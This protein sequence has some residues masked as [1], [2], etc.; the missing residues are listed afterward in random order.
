MLVHPG[1]V[2]VNESPAN[3]GLEYETVTLTSEDGYD[4]AAWYIPSQNGAA[5]ILQHGY[6]NNRTAMLPKAEIL[7]RHSY[8][9][10]MVDLRA[11]GLSEGD[12]VSFG[13][14]EVRDVDAA[15]QYL[16]SRPDVDPD[17]IGALGDS[18]GGAVVLLY[19]AQNPQIKAVVSEGAYASLQDV[20]ATGVETMTGLPAFPF[21]SMIQWFAEWEGGFDADEVAPIEQIGSIS[22]RPVFLM[23][24]GA[25]RLIPPDNGQR[26]YEAAGKPRELWFEPDLGHGRGSFKAER[27]EEYEA[28][29]VGFFDQYL[30]RE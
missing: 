6:P 17:R 1:R 9:V 18:M 26:L 14:F 2:P 12:T 21:A 28:R 3:Y 25:D 24:G 20:V 19:A 8:G 7:T 13:L 27:T 30:L 10:I 22:P 5:V 16:L 11:Q 15:Y 23:H 4:L 29:V